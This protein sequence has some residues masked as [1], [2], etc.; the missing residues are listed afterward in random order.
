MKKVLSLSIA[1]MLLVTACKKDK[2]DPPVLPPAE[3]MNIDFSNFDIQAKSVATKGTNMVNWE[4]AAT[5]A[6]TWKNLIGATLIIPVTSFQIAIDQTPSWV[7]EKTW[8][9]TYNATVATVTY[10]AKLT[11]VIKEPNVEWKMYITK[12]NAFTDF[13]WFEGTSKTDGTGGQW[14]LYKSNAE[15]VKILQID[16]TKSGSAI[17]SVKYT[18]IKTGDTF[19]NSYIEYGLNSNTP[20]NAYYTIHYYNGT[21]FSDVDVQ[22]STTNKTGRIKSV[23][24]LNGSWFCW[25][26]NH[27]N[28]TCA[29]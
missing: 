14:F 16:W 11:A 7:S 23:D 4:T 5:I 1:L 18:Y 15:P 24:Y 19:A 2:G 25:D 22:W 10:H 6:A 9:W 20:F 27:I 29:P 8:Q 26:Q 28:T 21:K 3:S 12:D 13:L 17:G